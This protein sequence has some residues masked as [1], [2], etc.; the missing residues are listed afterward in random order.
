MDDWWFK[1]VEGGVLVPV[2][3]IPVN[4]KTKLEKTGRGKKTD[5]VVPDPLATSSKWDGFM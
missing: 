3:L 1:R 4:G 2:T 5:D